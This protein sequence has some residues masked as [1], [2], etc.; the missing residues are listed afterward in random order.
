MSDMNEV[1]ERQE[2]ETRE[3]RRRRAAGKR[4]Q[5]ELDQQIVIAVALLKCGSQVGRGPNVDRHR[6]SRVMHDICNYDEY[7]VQ[8]KNVAEVDEI[9][10]MGKST[11]LDRLVRFCDVVETLYTKDYLHRPTRRDL[12]RLLQKAEAR[13]FP[14]MIGR[15]YGRPVD[16]LR[17]DHKRKNC[18]RVEKKFKNEKDMQDCTKRSAAQWQVV[19]RRTYSWFKPGYRL[20]EKEPKEKNER[21]EFRHKFMG[22]V[23]NKDLPYGGGIPPSSHLVEKCIRPTSV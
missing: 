3:R 21:K 7:F 20:F 15:P 17:D 1:L 4:V 23:L 11:T 13:G 12:Q 6:H 16:S 18:E 2:R 5:R 10:W 9:A 19:L 8:K 14:G 22:V